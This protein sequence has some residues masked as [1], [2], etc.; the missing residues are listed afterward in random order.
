[1][2][3]EDVH[4]FMKTLID[5]A[6]LWDGAQA[7]EAACIHVDGAFITY[8]GPRADAPRFSADVT[9]DARGGI[10]LPGLVNAHTHLPMTMVRGVGTDLPLMDW[11]H[12]IWPLEDKLTPDMMRLGTQMSA[13]EALRT[14]TTCFADAYM[15]SD[16]IARTVDE[17]GMRLNVC[18]MMTGDVTPDKL[19]EQKALFEEFNGAGDGRIRVYIGL[20]A[21]YTSEERLAREL[22][23]LAARLGTGL[24]VHVSE[25]RSEVEECRARRGGRSPVEYLCDVGAFDV[26]ALAAHCVWVDDNDIDILATKRVTAVHN[27]VSNLKLASGIAPV[28]R[29]CARGVNVA[30]GTDGA[31]SNNSMDMFEELKLA[32]ILQ[33]GATYSAT[34]MPATRALQ[35]SSQNGARALGYGDVG[36]LR[37][38]YRADIALLGVD[39]PAHT[40]A[41][42]IPGALVYAT[43]GADVRMTMVDGQV[44]YMDGEFKTLDQERI[45]AEYAAA[46]D[47]LLGK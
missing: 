12:M 18:R 42:D 11:L 25:T 16:V 46:V 17:A 34:A 30:L 23:G 38:G 39:N 15:M 2:T 8:A 1:M 4:T 35:I 14:G 10:A 6:R 31:S 43:S 40:A 27:P 22:A 26:P 21:E 41:R 20:H 5:N 33:K 24:H 13:L 29:M 19:A 45:R 37:P 47:A 44:L 32:A 7:V 28:E 3:G 9:I 36:L